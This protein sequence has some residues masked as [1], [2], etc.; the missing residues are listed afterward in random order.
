MTYVA[1]STDHGATWSQESALSSVLTDWSLVDSN[2]APN[3][4]DYNAL[5]ANQNGVYAAWSDGRNGDPDIFFSTLPS[6]GQATL[7]GTVAQPT[8]VHIQWQTPPRPS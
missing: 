8:R 5:F 2:I 7:T 4:G 6:P 3:Q 1:R